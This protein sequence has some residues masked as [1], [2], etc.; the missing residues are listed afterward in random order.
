MLLKVQVR[1]GKELSRVL[2][3]PTPYFRFVCVL[4]LFVEIFLFCYVLEAC[5]FF[6]FLGGEII[7]CV[8]SRF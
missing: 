2:I 6:F 3:S 8:L 7:G 5:K 1:M 4:V